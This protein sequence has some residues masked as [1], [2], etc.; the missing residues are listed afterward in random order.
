METRLQLDSQAKRLNLAFKKKLVHSSDTVLKV[1]GWID[2]TNATATLQTSLN[3]VGSREGGGIAQA[4]GGRGLGWGCPRRAPACQRRARPRPGPAGARDPESSRVVT[5]AGPPLPRSTSTLER[6]TP[7][8]RRHT[9]PT[10]G[11]G[12]GSARMPPPLRMTS[13]CGG[14]VSAVGRRARGFGDPAPARRHACQGRGVGTRDA[15]SG[16]CEAD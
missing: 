15:Q 2:T 5:G 16:G 3:K 13:S 11:C 9:S 1:D 14:Q 12:W 10:L 8:S 6:R 7:G 4:G